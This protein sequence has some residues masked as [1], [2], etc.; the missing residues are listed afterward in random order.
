MEYPQVEVINSTFEEWELDSRKFD[1]VVAT[2][3]FHWISPEVRYLKSAATLQDHGYLILLWNTPPQPSNEV[4]QKLVPVYQNL[5]PE[6]AKY[7]SIPTYLNNLNKFGKEA[8]DS[9][10][11]KNLISEYLVC[12]VVYSVDDY[13]ALLSTLSPYIA[14]EKSQRDDL[15]TALGKTLQQNYGEMIETS[16]LSLFHVVQK[17]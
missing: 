13:L 12:E 10:Y 11:F 9:G 2:T 1:A 4:Y 8:V 3:S 5:A 6:L 16:Y 15:F 17:N 14:L 7:E